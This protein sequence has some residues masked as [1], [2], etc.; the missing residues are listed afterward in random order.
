MR[1]QSYFNTA[2]LLISQYDGKVPLVHFL[3][4]YFSANK[5]HGSKDRKWI[6]HLCYSYYRLG[7]ALKELPSEERLR[8]ALFLCSEEAADWKILY[9]EKWLNTWSSELPVRI[10]FVQTVYPQ[11]CMTDIFPWIEALGEGVTAS[12]FAIAHLI[13]PDLF[14]RIR[15]GNE[16]QVLQKLKAENIPYTSI[17]SSCIGLPNATSIDKVL[18]IDK[19]V[20]VQDRNSQ[21]IAEFLQ[22]PKIEGSVSL[23]DCC[24]ASGGKSILAY[25][26]L[27]RVQLTVSDIRR[28]IIENLKKRFERAGI[29]KYQAFV[30]DVASFNI[31]QTAFNLI[32]CD[33]PCSGS[34]TW[35]RTPEQL[36]FFTKEKIGEYASLQKKILGNVVNSV[37]DNG[38]LLYITCSV[39]KQENEEMV[40]FIEG[41]N[42]MSL[43]Q[44]N[45]LEGYRGKADTMFAALFQKVGS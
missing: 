34:G 14:L 39:F 23:W 21:R 2:I 16:Q 11:F 29:R 28:L 4:Q 1:F 7:H 44:K 37:A 15:P 40:A 32:L 6:A 9:D 8:T 22:L 20:V 33:A 26:I 36:Y 25:D 5:K 35:A 3:K 19:E 41:S 42:G 43:V 27:A 17:S 30:H 45:L 13:Q 12:E 38:Y 24:A 18:D 10:A 31:H